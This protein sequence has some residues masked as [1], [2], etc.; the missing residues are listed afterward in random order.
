MK[1]INK[2]F[3]FLFL[4]LLITKSS[5]ADQLPGT[6]PLTQ[7]YRFAHTYITGLA[8]FVQQR[9]DETQPGRTNVWDWDYTDINSYKISGDSHRTNL[10]AMLGI[11]S[12]QTKVISNSWQNIGTGTF[13]SI[14][15]F[16]VFTEN[17]ITVRGIAAF[18]FSTNQV[19][20]V[21]I[22]V[23]DP[24]SPEV[25]LGI[26]TNNYDISIGK[27]FLEKGLAVICP[28]FI[29]HQEWWSGNSIV[30]NPSSGI[31]Q[32]NL[33]DHRRWL[34]QQGYHV[35]KQL[36]GDET[37]EIIACVNL[38]L[39][40]SRIITNSIGVV[41]RDFD[42]GASAFFAAALEDKIQ[43]V[44]L[45]GYYNKRTDIWKQY[46][47]HQFFGFLC[48]FGDAEIA[49]L[50]APQPLIIESPI[51][52]PKV[53]VNTSSSEFERA[54]I[55]YDNL[56]ESNKINFITPPGGTN[57]FGCTEVIDLFIESLNVDTGNYYECA[58]VITSSYS[59]INQMKESFYETQDWY[60]QLCSNSY[61]VRENFFW[62]NIDT[63]SVANYQISTEPFHSNLL[64]EV[65]GNVPEADIPLQA[66]SCL[67]KSNE[68]FV[69]YRVL[70]TLYTNVKC[71]GLLNVPY[72]I[73]EGEK[74][75]CVVCQHGLEGCPIYHQ[76]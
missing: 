69:T 50:I 57:I 24:Y 66:W 44:L 31:V 11:T 18:P 2:F 23:T 47:E 34:F 64:Y 16:S 27:K 51:D 60:Q 26:D 7:I 74:R 70:M 8:D 63:S 17:G 38:L 9:I 5:F 14:E 53:S 10:T 61:L 1:K 72:G 65:F 35:G 62:D 39:T 68:H 45:S 36:I 41:G 40:D 21:I 37:A 3:I 55:H 73:K 28:V 12:D 13:Y 71:Y 29:N 43:A 15:K 42:S 75:A 22:P 20:A 48:E 25:I 30:T 4:T 52:F 33:L 46:I 19:P 58:L 6:E 32:T 49:S 59:H 56:G 54:K 67:Y 76:T